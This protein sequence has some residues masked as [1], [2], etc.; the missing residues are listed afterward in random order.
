MKTRLNEEP[1]IS[2]LKEAAVS[3]MP[4]RRVRIPRN[5]LR[6]LFFTSML[7]FAVVVL[8]YTRLHR[9]VLLSEMNTVR[10]KQSQKHFV[11]QSLFNEFA[12]RKERK[13]NK[14]NYI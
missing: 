2:A 12:I 6:L 3:G 10:G 8:H 4:I 14:S 7:M 5:L 13:S 1:F 9:F 11:I